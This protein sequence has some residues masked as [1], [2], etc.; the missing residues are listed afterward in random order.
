M[1]RLRQYRI[2][3]GLCFVLSPFATT[4]TAF[5]QEVILSNANN[6]APVSTTSDNT[7]LAL[8]QVPM[9]SDNV[10]SLP[11]GEPIYANSLDNPGGAALAFPSR[12]PFH[13]TLALS[14]GYDDNVNSGSGGSSISNQTSN[15]TGSPFVNGSLALGYEFGTPRTRVSLQTG[16]SITYYTDNQGGGG[17]EYSGYLGLQ[18]THK[19]STRMTLGASLYVIYTAEPNFNLNLGINRRI[20]GYIYSTDQLTLN[21]LWT[22][23]FSTLSSYT[24]GAF[25]QQ[26]QNAP[27]TMPGD[28]SN[29]GNSDNRIENTFSNQFR[30]LLL[31]TTTV[32]IEYRLGFI[33]YQQN[34]A[35]DSTTN[36]LLAGLDHTF[37]PRLNASFHAGVEYRSYS[38][39]GD[40]VSPTFEADVG[41]ILGRRSSIGWFANYGLQPADIVGSAQRTTFRTGINGRYNWTARIS[42]S[43]GVI[44]EHD[45]YGNPSGSSITGPSTS[46]DT[47]NLVL[48]ARYAVTRYF[49]IQVGYN[50]TDVISNQA[51]GVGV[52]PGFASGGA[53]QSYTRNR[54]SAGIDF[55]F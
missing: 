43:I 54:I 32:L 38:S 18:F 37:S 36:A 2:I 40:S 23:R 27:P 49:G 44:Y 39:A 30:F 46:Q 51:L 53:L 4:R 47:I 48:S 45:D 19:A 15:Q 8:P 25:F 35:F 52:P 41:Y 11:T 24:F 33:T 26:G 16:G 7:G 34:S 29:I 17:P 5:A 12:L 1:H 3:V 21:Y 9:T 14:A 6:E 28:L 13:L 50:F 22:P 10:L 20:G 31:P 42:S 55:T